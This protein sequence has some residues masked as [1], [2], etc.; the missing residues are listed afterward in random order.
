M[1]TVHVLLAEGSLV[2]ARLFEA[3][4]VVAEIPWRVHWVVDGKDALDFLR[5][6]GRFRGKPRPDLI[7]LG[8][9]MSGH[10]ARETLREIRSHNP[11]RTLPAL[12]WSSSLETD[13]VLLADRRRAND[14]V[15]KP[16]RL[17]ELTGA[18]RTIHQFWFGA[19]TPVRTEHHLPQF[20]R[21]FPG[22]ALRHAKPH[23]H[24]SCADFTP[25]MAHAIS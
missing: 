22:Q 23:T 12:L 20:A 11:L 3:A 14:D 10:S 18:L 9:F 16:T 13:G 7:V 1:R 21:S 24:F 17:D 25:W 5:R 4:V 8:G 19:A 2:Q 15:P 6:H